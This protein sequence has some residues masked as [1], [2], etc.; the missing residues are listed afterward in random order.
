MPRKAAEMG[1]RAL[2]RLAEP[3]T[4]AVG[5]VPGL[6]VVV[7]PN[8][9]KCWVLR[10]KVG[11]RIG[12]DGKPRPIRREF[13]LGGYPEVSLATARDKARELREQVRQGIDPAQERKAAQTRLIREQQA[14]RTFR[15]IAEETYKVKAAEFKNPKHAAQ[16]F[17]TLETYVF[18]SI[19]DMPINDVTTAD[20][21]DLLK[22]IWTEKAETASRVR[23]RMASVFQFAMV[24]DH[25][26]RTNPLNPADWK[27]L[28]EKLPA[29][30]KI[31]RKAGTKHH[32]ALPVAEVPRLM[33]DLA[34]RDAISAKALRFTILTAAR[35]GE[36][37][38]ATWDEFDL[39]ARVWRLPAE[40]MKSDKAHAV[41]LSDA[42]VSILAALPRDNPAGLV[43][44]SAKGVELSDMTLSRCSRTRT[45]PT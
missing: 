42:A 2:Q 24:G 38:L 17:C 13:G 33:A 20:V 15:Q 9:A 11:E 22:P 8:L 28:K 7:T 5:V 16:W 27:H 37:R 18:P 19:G 14:Q 34:T 35:S 32:P 3:G 36:V 39:D 12:K 30:S 21:L 31:K 1:A 25:P 40:R 29:T 43:F 23:Q 41:P 10:V 45:R 44:P 4:H 26:I 6:H